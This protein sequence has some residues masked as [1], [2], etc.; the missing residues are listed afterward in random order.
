MQCGCRLI[1]PYGL[2][3]LRHAGGPSHNPFE[4][5]LH[6]P[7]VRGTPNGAHAPFLS[8]LSAE[9]TVLKGGEQ[10]DQSSMPRA[11]LMSALR[12]D[13]H[14]VLRVAQLNGPLVGKELR[15][16]RH[17]GSLMLRQPDD[18]FAPPRQHGL[19][20]SEFRYCRD[21]SGEARSLVRR[22][23]EV[24]REC[25]WLV[26]SVNGSHCPTSSVAVAHLLKI[27]SPVPHSVSLDLR[28]TGRSSRTSGR[29]AHMP[30]HRR[31]DSSMRRI[32][33]G[34]RRRWP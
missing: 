12:I 25:P 18:R 23:T 9:G 1:A 2:R 4:Q 15:I 26:V 13:A 22:R 24:C 3:H 8:Q 30:A 21:E 10:T 5:S 6:E 28:C 29:P 16:D 31:S 34:A 17:L 33:S 20:V 27:M 32:G 19:A 11:L 7:I 14:Q